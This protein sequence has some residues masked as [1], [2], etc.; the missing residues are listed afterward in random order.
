[1]ILIFS[2]R[3]GSGV[4]IDAFLSG[5]CF[6]GSHGSIIEDSPRLFATLVAILQIYLSSDSIPS[7]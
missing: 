2:T 1:M 7:G 4:E 6:I 3:Q 5:V